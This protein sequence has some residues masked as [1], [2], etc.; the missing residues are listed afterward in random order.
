MDG[1]RLRT[2]QPADR[3]TTA[4]PVQRQSEEQQAIKEEP[5]PVQRHVSNYRS[6]T[7]NEKSSKRFVLPVIGLLILVALVVG[8]FVWSRSDTPATAIKTDRYQAV[9]FTNG[10]VYFGKLQPFDGE[11]MK[12]TE[13]YYLQA[14]ASAETDSR[15]PQQAS[16]DQSNVQLIKLGGE[17]HGPEDEMII[18]KDQMLFYENLKTDGKV[19]QSIEKYKQSN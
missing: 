17:V 10:Q 15:N 19:A 3:R 2:P 7:K 4:R 1:G 6:A 9:F 16:S 14:Q 8:W 12:L 11:Y 13:V 5:K 18:S